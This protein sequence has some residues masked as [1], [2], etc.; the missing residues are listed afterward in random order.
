MSNQ[1]VIKYKLSFKKWELVRTKLKTVS[2]KK[3]LCV[4][5][6]TGGIEILLYVIED[7]QLVVE[8]FNVTSKNKLDKFFKK[9]LRHGLSEKWIDAYMDD[10]GIWTKGSFDDHM[11]IVDQV[12]ECLARDDMKCNPLKCKWAV[13]E[14]DFLG[15]HIMAPI[16]YRSNT[17]EE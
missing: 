2:Q 17:D 3:E 5:F 7:I 10:F 12:L 11:I 1:S 4:T 16:A 8:S 14:T 9:I 13:K 6:G 15:H